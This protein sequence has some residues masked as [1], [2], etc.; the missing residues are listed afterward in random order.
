MKYP[1]LLL[2]VAAAGCAST[3]KPETVVER[4]AVPTYPNLPNLEPPK[5]FE[6]EKFKLDVPRDMSAAPVVKPTAECKAV[7]AAKRDDAFWKR[8]GEQPPLANSNI[9][10]GFDEFN[11]HLFEDFLATR[12]KKDAA[13]QARIDEVNRQREEWRKKNDAVI[14]EL[15]AAP[16]APAEA[17]KQK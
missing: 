12:A 1:I 16:A 2:A 15:G 5:G 17:P 11:Y 7:T 8:C 3:P 4:V 6:A 13:W 14:A 9:F 10:I